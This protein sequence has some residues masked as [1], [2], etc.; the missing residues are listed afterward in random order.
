MFLEVNHCTR[1]YH[2]PQ[3]SFV[4]ISLQVCFILK[5]TFHSLVTAFLSVAGRPHCLSL[6]LEQ[7]VLT[8]SSI[9]GVRTYKKAQVLCPCDLFHVLIAFGSREQRRKGRRLEFNSEVWGCWLQKWVCIASHYA[10]RKGWECRG[11]R[12][13]RELYLVGNLCCPTQREQPGLGRGQGH[14]PQKMR[15]PSFA[16]TK[17]GCHQERT[18][19]ASQPKMRSCHQNCKRLTGLILF[20]QKEFKMGTFPGLGICGM[21]QCIAVSSSFSIAAPGKGCLLQMFP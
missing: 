1:L 2:I 16:K 12:T 7:V 6:W 15:G 11:G 18:M 19:D 21:I 20:V 3:A 4:R 17:L 14:C 10:Q 13:P 8:L 5:L 9:S